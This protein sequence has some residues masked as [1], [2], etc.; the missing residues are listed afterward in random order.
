MPKVCCDADKIVFSCVKRN[1]KKWTWNHS[2]I[3]LGFVSPTLFVSHFS[4][5]IFISKNFD[6]W[7]T[8]FKSFFYPLFI[9]QSLFWDKKTFV[10]ICTQEKFSSCSKLPMRKSME[11]FV[12]IFKQLGFSSLYNHRQKSDAV[13]K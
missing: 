8:A 6:Q 3:H 12:K 10:S 11:G 2:V 4:S 1:P 7:I 13:S 9:I 5:R